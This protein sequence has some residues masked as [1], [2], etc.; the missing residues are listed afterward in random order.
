M[1]SALAL[2]IGGERV[3]IDQILEEHRLE[4]WDLD[5]ISLRSFLRANAIATD[6]GHRAMEAGRPAIFDGCFYW[7]EQLDDLAE[8]FGGDLCVFTLE[9]PLSVCIERD[10]TRPLPGPEEEPRGGHQLGEKAVRDVYKLV[11]EVQYG[12]F[13][14]ASGPV[15]VTVATIRKHLPEPARA[16]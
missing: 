10:R 4:E 11:G 14:D 1:A 3:S 5:R 13:I 12:S 2:S 9:A 15:A 16:H 8:R 6:R 7:R